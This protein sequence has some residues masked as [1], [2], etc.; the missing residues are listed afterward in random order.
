[1][2]KPKSRNPATAKAAR[3]RLPNSAGM[4][5]GREGLDRRGIRLARRVAG[6]APREPKSGVQIGVQSER[7]WE[8]RRHSR[9]ALE[10]QI[11][12]A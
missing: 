5:A 9:M 6:D 7:N 10:S 12:P 1:M 8:V 2:A 4:G 11:A 3:R